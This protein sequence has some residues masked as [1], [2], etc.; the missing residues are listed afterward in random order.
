MMSSN[1]TDFYREIY[2]RGALS[3]YR[4]YD[5][6]RVWS[7]ICLHSDGRGHH[8]LLSAVISAVARTMTI[9]SIETLYWLGGERQA[10]AVFEW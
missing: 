5:E 9:A 7:E 2:S 8:A 4:V 1:C 6:V 10:V 3:V